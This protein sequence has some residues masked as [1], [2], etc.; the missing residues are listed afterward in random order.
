VDSLSLAKNEHS[1]AKA[2]VLELCNVY[3]GNT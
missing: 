1:N 3:V 2:K